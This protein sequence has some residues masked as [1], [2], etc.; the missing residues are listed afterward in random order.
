[1]CLHLQTSEITRIA[2]LLLHDG[3]HNGQRLVPAQYI[4][5]M[6]AVT[7]PTGMAEP[8]LQTYGLHVWR[9]SRDR[10]WRMDGLYGQLG[11]VL[12]EHEACV[13]VTAH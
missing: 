7:T 2:R 13:S 10:A 6:T 11:I 8:D 4:A 1:M 5:S 9:R 12:P 3:V